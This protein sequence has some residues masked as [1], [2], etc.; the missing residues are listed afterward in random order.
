MLF[1]F[2]LFLFQPPNA[3]LSNSTFLQPSFKLGFIGSNIFKR[4]FIQRYFTQVSAISL[5]FFFMFRSNA[6]TRGRFLPGPTHV[7]TSCNQCTKLRGFQ[8]LIETFRNRTAQ[9][10]KDVAHECTVSRDLSRNSAVLSLQSVL[11]RKVPTQER[12]RSLSSKPRKWQRSLPIFFAVA[13]TQ[14]EDALSVAEQ[15]FSFYYPHHPT[16]LFSLNWGNVSTS[17]LHFFLEKCFFVTGIAFLARTVNL[18]PHKKKR[19]DW[20]TNTCRIKRGFCGS[21]EDGDMLKIWKRMKK[22]ILRPFRQ[23]QQQQ[24]SK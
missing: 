13:M 16:K 2:F 10:R 19:L 15:C 14:Q 7:W 24:Q 11:L 23:K 22:M 6:G 5:F 17:A 3:T 9:G 8:P 18:L 12:P 21:G 1:F 4:Y 20:P